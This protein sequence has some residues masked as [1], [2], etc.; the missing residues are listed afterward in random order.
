MLSIESGLNDGLATPFVILA[1]AILAAE[2]TVGTDWVVRAL[3][4]TVVG[5]AVGVAVGLTGG[6]LLRRADRAHWASPVSR[7][8]FVL[9]LAASCYLA[10][11]GAGGNGFIAAFVGGLAF[12]RGSQGLEKG[13]VRFTETQ[14]S[15][16]A[17]AVWVAFGLTVAGRLRTDL[18]DPAAIVYAVLSLT[19]IRMVPVVIALIGLRFARPT[20]L[21]VGWFGPRGL[22]SIVF[23]IIGLEGLDLAGVDSG[24]LGGAVAWTVLLSVIAHGLT[25]GPLARAYA[26]RIATLP[27]EAPEFE[28]DVQPQPSRTVWAGRTGSD[29]GDQGP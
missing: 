1:L 17:I 6:V 5:V 23:L 25:A 13:A 10:A 7:Q 20:I 12:G 16:L 29:R 18:W 3:Q 9:A 27:A 8:L 21:F 19:I 4:E 2:T 28:H 14:G 15:L 22:A 26:R 11:V 24:P